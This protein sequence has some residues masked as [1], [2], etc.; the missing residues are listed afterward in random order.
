MT[1]HTAVP[2]SS[3]ELSDALSRIYGAALDGSTWP[4]AIEAAARLVGADAAAGVFDASGVTAGGCVAWDRRAGA[5]DLEADAAQAIAGLGAGTGGGAVRRIGRAVYLPCGGAAPAARWPEGESPV[6]AIAGRFD[7]G[8]AGSGI[9]LF[10]FGRRQDDE[11]LAGVGRL[12]PHI[13]RAA[14]IGA[15]LDGCRE[16]A[17]RAEILLDGLGAGMVL[18]SERMR[19]IHLNRAARALLA[20]GDCLRSEDGIIHAR[21]PGTT[22]ELAEAVARSA[23]TPGGGAV[24]IAAFRDAASPVVLHVVGLES[25]ASAASM[26]DKPC[27]AIV[28]MIPNRLPGHVLDAVADLYDLTPAEASVFAQ[29]AIGKTPA[30]VAQTLGIAA[31]TVRT[32]LLRLFDKT[33][34]RRQSDLVRLA[35]DL[36]LP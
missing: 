29:I 14:A 28:V 31:S 10:L 2:R 23:R 22:R 35:R 34:V 15:R 9:V 27:A 7:L 16:A 19:I 3:V 33:G 8:R 36:S 4:V 30:E 5:C 11:A 17:A 26:A 6:D 1:S 12:L 25:R 24:T 32:H 18:V 13:A 21:A 20:R